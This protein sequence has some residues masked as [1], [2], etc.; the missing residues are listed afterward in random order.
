MVNAFGQETGAVL[1]PGEHNPNAR[2]V[3]R[4][5]DGEH[6][7]ALDAEGMPAARLHEAPGD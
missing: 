1:M 3:E 2:P 4:V 6:L 5:H 7:A